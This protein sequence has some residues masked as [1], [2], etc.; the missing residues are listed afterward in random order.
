V[1]LEQKCD[2]AEWAGNSCWA[3]A[4]LHVPVSQSPDILR[5]AVMS[6]MLSVKELHDCS[7]TQ[8]V[9]DLAFVLYKTLVW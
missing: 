9:R 4:H 8:A 1:F 6:Q 2:C 7:Y 5:N 3:E